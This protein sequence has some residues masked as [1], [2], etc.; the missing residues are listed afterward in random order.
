MNLAQTI[1][2]VTVKGWCSVQLVHPR[3]GAIPRAVFHYC[4]IRLL[5]V[6]SMQELC[7]I[8]KV[9]NALFVYL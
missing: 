4:L 1:Y 7:F 2:M 6:L 3:Y 9:T 5:Y 8:T